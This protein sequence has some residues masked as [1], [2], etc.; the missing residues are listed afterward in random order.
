LLISDHA[1]NLQNL[2]VPHF[3]VNMSHFLCGASWRRLSHTIC[4]RIPSSDPPDTRHCFEFVNRNISVHIF[5][6]ARDFR[7]LAYVV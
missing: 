2:A 1:L 6:E 3:S 4:K 5:V 7:L